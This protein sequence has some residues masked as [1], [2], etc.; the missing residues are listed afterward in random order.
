MSKGGSDATPCWL[1]R[2]VPTSQR[3]GLKDVIK[4]NWDKDGRTS[5]LW[6]G[7]ASQACFVPITIPSSGYWG[8]GIIVIRRGGAGRPGKEDVSAGR[9]IPGNKR[10]N[11]HLRP[12]TEKFL[13]MSGGRGKEQTGQGHRL[14]V[15]WSESFQQV[16]GLGPWPWSGEH[17]WPG[18]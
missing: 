15:C 8:S 13:I 1:L 9:Q 16:Q 10:Q 14:G 17:R 7:Q 18:T 6:Q 5:Q 11:T 12:H 3:S 2:A 4:G